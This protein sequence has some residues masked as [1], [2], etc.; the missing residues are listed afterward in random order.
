MKCTVFK[1]S[2]GSMLFRTW[3][4]TVAEKIRV[5][6]AVAVVLS[7]LDDAVLLNTTVHSG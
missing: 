3:L 5:D 4:K 7:E 2:N 6:A 1:Y